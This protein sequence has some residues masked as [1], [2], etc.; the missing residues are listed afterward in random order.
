M[1]KRS[2]EGSKARLRFLF[3][4]IG[5]SSTAPKLWGRPWLSL[6]WTSTLMGA[7]RAERGAWQ[8]APALLELRRATPCGPLPGG[9]E[10]TLTLRD[11]RESALGWFTSL[12]GWNYGSKELSG[13]LKG[14]WDLYND[15]PQITKGPSSV[16]GPSR[17]M[18]AVLGRIFELALPT[19]V[20]TI[21]VGFR[22]LDEHFQLSKKTPNCQFLFLAC[23][24]SRF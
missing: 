22:E 1:V 4:R 2:L 10:Q 6:W 24:Q 21:W 11:V 5:L 16:S 8:D 19:I 23:F 13:L 17:E 9:Q 12:W 3:A 14:R 7:E 18:A 15:G 20:Q